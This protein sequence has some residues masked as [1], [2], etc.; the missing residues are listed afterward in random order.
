MQR[1]E[2][3]F[4]RVLALLWLSRLLRMAKIVPKNA[5]NGIEFGYR[6]G[7]PEVRTQKVHFTNKVGEILRS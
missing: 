4:L 5:I 1:A 6:V 3:F 7:Q 2:P